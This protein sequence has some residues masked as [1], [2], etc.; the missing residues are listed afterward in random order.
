[1]GGILLIPRLLPKRLD[2]T[3]PNAITTILL[4]SWFTNIEQFQRQTE[5][6]I[7]RREVPALLIASPI[8]SCRHLAI[9]NKT[10]DRRH[11][12]VSGMWGRLSYLNTSTMS[13]IR[14]CFLLFSVQSLRA[15]GWGQTSIVEFP[16]HLRNQIFT[17]LIP[18]LLPADEQASRILS[19]TADVRPQPA[20]PEGAY[21]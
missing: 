7:F 2:G 13:E 3:G 10:Y 6:Y 11:N 14:S 16:A 18:R 9:Q 4:M 8:P 20:V 19:G 21:A 1:M 12:N 17:L 15:K 5:S